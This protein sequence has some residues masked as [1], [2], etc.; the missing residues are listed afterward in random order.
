MQSSAKK[1]PRVGQPRRE[2]AL[3][4]GAHHR[5]V[6]G[7]RR[8][9]RREARR[10][11]ATLLEREVALVG[12]H[13][14]H[15]GL[16]GDLEEPA[17][18]AAG[19][20]NRVLAQAGDLVEQVVVLAHRAAGLGGQPAQ[21]GL[22]H[23]PARRRVDDHER[24]AQ[25]VDVVA[26]AGQVDR[27]GREEAV[28]V[29]GAAGGDAGV[30]HRHHLAAVQRHQPVQRPHEPDLAPAPAHRLGPR[31]RGDQLGQERRQ[32][33][34]RRLAGDVAGRHRVQ[35]LLARH[36]GLREGRGIDAVLGGE[37]EAGLGDGAVGGERG[38]D[39]RTDD[40]LV[41]IGLAIGEA[42][43]HQRQPAR[44]A[45]RGHLAVRQPGG[46]EAGLGQR[47]QVHQRARQHP[48]RDLFGPQL[49]QQITGHGPPP[50][51]AATPRAPRPAPRR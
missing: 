3:V 1:K 37:A 35:A 48:R 36:L 27:A 8:R 43:H 51:R 49:E 28:A 29:G 16:L 45:Q 44:R 42:A 20:P 13:R 50:S 34:G 18:E 26:G 12:A 17:I 23:L 22:D 24:R 46:V 2:H 30:A 4:A 38:A 14:Q 11:A 6:L 32:H 31:D 21:L 41:E 25:R 9:D 5:G 40:A 7:D 33:G 10:Q 39:R 47:R 15:Q 19:D